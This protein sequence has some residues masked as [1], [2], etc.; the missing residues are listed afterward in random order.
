MIN[1]YFLND[2]CRGQIGTFTLNKL[3]ALAGGGSTENS[4]ALAFPGYE[5]PLGRR[6]EGQPDQ[7]AM[8]VDAAADELDA[9]LN[10][11]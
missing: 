7:D 5:S 2:R 8:D 6:S 9:L 1:D 4:D 11:T 10:S 3:R